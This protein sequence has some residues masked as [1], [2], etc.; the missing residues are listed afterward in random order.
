[1]RSLLV[2]AVC[3]FA[4]LPVLAENATRT[5][6]YTIHHNALTTE[7]LSPEVAASYG[8]QRSQNRA[9]INISI[10]KDKF[11]ALGEP[12]SGQVRLTARNLIG[13]LR[14]LP[15]REIREEN[16]I[17]YIS[18]FPVSDRERLVFDVEVKLAN[19]PYP[20]RAHFVQ[21]FHT[22]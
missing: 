5:M 14:E 18:D 2:L 20:L 19:E 11:G 21:V 22:N 15:L 16:A 8:I 12:Q 3:L 4:S 6:G 1:M 10:I 7:I 17:Y 13:Q 9:L